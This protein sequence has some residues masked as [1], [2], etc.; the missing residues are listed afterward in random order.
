MTLPAS[1]PL[2]MSQVNSELALVSTTQLSFSQT[3]LRTLAGVLSGDISMSSLR[4]KS[5]RKSIS[6]TVNASTNEYNVYSSASA[7]GNY[8]AGTSDIV[9]TIGVGVYISSSSE[10]A[11][12]LTVSGFSTGDTVTINNYGQIYGHGGRGGSGGT[13]YVSVSSVGFQGGTAISLNF[14][15]TI[16]NQGAIAGGGGGGGGG[17]LKTYTTL[18]KPS[19]TYYIG[20][21]GGGG[22]GGSIYGSTGGAGGSFGYSTYGGTAGTAG[23]AGTYLFGGGRG[24]GGS[25]GGI[26][27]LDGGA[28]GDLG[29]AGTKA[30]DDPG[31]GGT[32]AGAAG[33]AAGYYISGGSYATWAATGTR[34]GLAG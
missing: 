4:G 2:S 13:L 25:Y 10:A 7:T 17:S 6:L 21:G 30:Q 11:P 31:Y 32:I 8:V 22:G 16:N 3:V 18:A 26:L 24:A 5:N 29:A 1:G 27:G 34:L 15:T 14:A 20:G 19:G 33:G 12:A 23:V 9:L 28:G